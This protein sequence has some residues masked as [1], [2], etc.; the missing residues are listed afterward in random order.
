MN[1][2]VASQISTD[3]E[4]VSKLLDCNIAQTGLGMG[5]DAIQRFNRA[6]SVSTKEFRCDGQYQLVSEAFC[7]NAGYNLRPTLDHQ[8]FYMLFTQPAEKVIKSYT[9]SWCPGHS[10]YPGSRF[11][12]FQLM[13]F[14]RIWQGSDD[15]LSFSLMEE[16]GGG[17]SP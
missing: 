9:T 17:W 14:A 10:D 5:V 8:G 2:L 13:R 6:D 7:Q 3:H 11:Y 16:L 15:D 1:R 12:Q 4:V